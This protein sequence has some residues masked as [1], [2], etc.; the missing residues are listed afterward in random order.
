MQFKKILKNIKYNLKAAQIYEDK[1]PELW[2]ASK[3]MAHKEIK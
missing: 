3:V 2:T 1:L